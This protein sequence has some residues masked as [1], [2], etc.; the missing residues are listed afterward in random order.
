MLPAVE[1]GDPEYTDNFICSNCHHRDT[2]P[3]LD[4]LLSQSVSALSG[5]T[6]CLYLL[7]TQLS[8]IFHGFQHDTLDKPL[9]TI[10]LALVATIFLSGFIYVLF[11]ANEGFKH[12]SLYTKQTS[13]S[14]K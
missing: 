2:I 9:S 4:L 10:S 7:S 12:R 14:Y 5:I 11:K 6:V 13:A 1:E 3:T 8:K